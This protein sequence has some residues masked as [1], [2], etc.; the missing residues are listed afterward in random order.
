MS[1]F[2]PSK[3]QVNVELV[4]APACPHCA[5][6]LQILT[7]LIKSSD[8]AELYVRDLGQLPKLASQLGIRSVPWIKIGSF[9]LTGALTKSEIKTWIDRLSSDSGMQAYFS[10]LF[11]SGELDKVLLLVNKH[12]ELLQHFPGMMADDSTPLGAKIGIGAVFESLQ[13]SSAI[14][15]LI[16]QLAGLIQSE[17]VNIRHDACYYLGLTETLEALPHIQTLLKDSNKEIR[18][19][20][21]DALNMLKNED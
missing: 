19:T 9:E 13:G 3:E 8:I 18:E 17:N 15:Q 11:T 7:E 2:E 16:P 14:K 12:P 10:E 4:I 20:A 6:V 5:N 21:N 1:K